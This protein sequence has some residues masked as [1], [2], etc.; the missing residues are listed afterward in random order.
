M[1]SL[2]TISSALEH[3]GDGVVRYGIDVGSLLDSSRAVRTKQSSRGMRSDV[4]FEVLR[5]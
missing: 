3:D 4:Y 5:A 2:I 1:T